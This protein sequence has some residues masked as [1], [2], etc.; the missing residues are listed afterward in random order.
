MIF[1][2]ADTM[3][4]PATAIKAIVTM[5]SISVPPSYPY[6]RKKEKELQ[7]VLQNPF[8]P[9]II[10]CIELYFMKF[11]NFLRTADTTPV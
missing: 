10:R 1:M 8:I 7:P 9:Y 5:V 3:A 11:M 4:I 2:M 6:F